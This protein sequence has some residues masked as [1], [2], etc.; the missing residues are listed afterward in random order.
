M[1]I[2]SNNHIQIIREDREYDELSRRF[3][4]PS[5]EIRYIDFNRTGVFLKD[6]QVRVGFR[7]RFLTNLPNNKTIYFAV[8]VR[9]Q[10]DTNF[11]IVGREI[12]F[13]DQILGYTDRVELDTCDMSY[14]RGSTRLN[15]N[16]RKRSACGGCRA[17]IHNYR[18][19]Y[20]SS[21]IHDTDALI[22]YDQLRNF[23][24]NQEQQGLDISSLEQIAVVTGL[25]GGENRIVE[26][27]TIIRDIVE[28]KGFRGELLYF[29]CEVNTLPALQKLK[30]LGNFTLVYAIDNFSKRD[31]ILNPVK[32]R[33]LEEIMETMDLAKNCGLNVTYSYIAGID[34]INVIEEVAPKLVPYVA[35][36]PIV[37]VYQVQTQ[38]QID[39]MDSYAKSLEYY[40]YVRLIFERLFGSTNMRPRRWENYRPLW[41]DEFNGE[42]LNYN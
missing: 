36:F 2:L 11:M 39:T 13:N 29:G 34:S 21:V 33:S 14:M 12:K 35:R 4:L 38:G 28:P 31:R 37:N 20:D 42:P 40:L 32:S 23:F 7:A 8:P 22:T 24:Y 3:T 5:P 15:L 18:N 26:H 41:Y 10:D 1:G 27:M 9:S 16:S 30:S 19:F 6:N 25:F 17:C